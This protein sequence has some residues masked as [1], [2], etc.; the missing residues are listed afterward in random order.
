MSK[1]ILFALIMVLVSVV[2]LMAQEAGVDT[3]DI[4]YR[5][6]YKIGS[7]LPI[8]IILILAILFIRKAFRFKE[9]E[10]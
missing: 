10:K 7:Y 8:T 2:G 5:I 4:R 6:G 1:K 9:G 3:T